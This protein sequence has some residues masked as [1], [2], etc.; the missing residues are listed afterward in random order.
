MA[1][2]LSAVN[3]WLS[4]G[5]A[6]GRVAFPQHAQDFAGKVVLV[7]E[8]E[9]IVPSLLIIW[10]MQGRNSKVWLVGDMAHSMD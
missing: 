8:D 6:K 1:Q 4:H 3:G 10:G 7:Q 9:K 2:K 5:L